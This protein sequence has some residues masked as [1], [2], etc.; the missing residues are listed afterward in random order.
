MLFW[1][2]IGVLALLGFNVTKNWGSYLFSDV[3]FMS[4]ALGESL[5]SSEIYIN[6]E[7]EISRK[8]LTL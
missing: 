8:I 4:M 3:L 7:L 6:S 1:F 5:K 2:P